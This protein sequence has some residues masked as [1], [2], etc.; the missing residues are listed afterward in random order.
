MVGII[1]SPYGSDEVWKIAAFAVFFDYSCNQAR[2]VLGIRFGIYR[3]KVACGRYHELTC[4]IDE[5]HIVD[6][7]A[8]DVV[9]FADVVGYIFI[10]EKPVGVKREAFF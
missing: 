10:C 5:Y 1:A 9:T 8:H 6:Q 2:D 7:F 3:I 4:R